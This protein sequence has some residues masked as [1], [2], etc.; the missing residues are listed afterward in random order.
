MQELEATWGRVISVWWLLAWRG[1]LGAVLIGAVVGFIIGF[2]GA[3]AHV[4]QETITLL[5][6]IAGALVGLAW[7][8]MVVRMALRKRYGEFR[9]ALVPN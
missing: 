6:S 2:I 5:S 3:L 9:L 7:A 4:S 8:I 1:L